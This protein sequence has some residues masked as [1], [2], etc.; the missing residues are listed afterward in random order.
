[1]E[2]L[3]LIVM[4]MK[5]CANQSMIA[6]TVVH[7]HFQVHH[8]R[9]AG[10]AVNCTAQGVLF[11]C[12]GSELGLI[13]GQRQFAVIISASNVMIL[14]ET[15]MLRAHAIKELRQARMVRKLIQLSWL[16]RPHNQPYYLHIK[17]RQLPQSP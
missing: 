10:V 9:C 8:H 4:K 15:M 7:F 16:S 3:I 12:V 5:Y 11:S 6:W 1:M 13:Q 17:W 14:W 2:C